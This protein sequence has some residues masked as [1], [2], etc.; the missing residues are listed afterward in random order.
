M[1]V[2][3]LVGLALALAL[4]VTV[5]D[6]SEDAVQL[7]FQF[8]PGE[9]MTYGVSV[10]GAGH[11]RSPEGETAAVGLQGD[12]T[13]VCTVESVLDDGSGRLQVRV[14]RADLRVNVGED[15]ARFSYENG[16]VRWFA[17]GQ[18]HAPP[19]ADLSQVPLLGA[20]VRV[21]MAPNGRLGDVVLADPRLMGALRQEVPGIGT[22]R[23]AQ[24]GEEVFPDRPVAVGETWRKSAQLTPFGPG[25]PVTL[26]TSHTLDSF[27]QEGGIGVAKISGYSE[28]RFQA[29][30]M[31][32][33]EGDVAVTVGVPRLRETI[34][35]TE[36]FDT[37]QGR[38]LRADYQVALSAQASVALGEEERE[39]EAEARFHI[40]VQAR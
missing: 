10:S 37:S 31:P 4:G 33:S 3:R 2:A 17:N 36:F 8:S 21:T 35:S 27:S 29:A 19:D 12:L 32:V 26:T 11:L 13:F 24:V 30:K 18:E 1:K 15:A 7:A 9:V 34:T 20:P 25:M 38:L 5:A 14:P 22:G 28:V 40:T 6:G 23:L 16:R 39:A